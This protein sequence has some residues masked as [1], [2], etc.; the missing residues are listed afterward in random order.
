M[1]A[2]ERDTTEGMREPPRSLEAFAVGELVILRHRLEV[3]PVP[4]E[5]PK[6]QRE[7]TRLL[8]DGLSND[9]IA[10]RRNVAARTIANQVA[11]IFRRLG[12]SSRAELVR[13]CLVRDRQTHVGAR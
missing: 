6:A 13:W 4:D 8:L 10:R 11:S 9:A 2:A 3:V 5:L 1:D 12:V 7:V